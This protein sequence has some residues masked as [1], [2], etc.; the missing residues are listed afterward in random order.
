MSAV[1][2]C[3]LTRHHALLSSHRCYPINT[4]WVSPIIFQTFYYMAT[5]LAIEIPG[6]PVS[7]YAAY[8]VATLVGTAILPSLVYGI[9]T[10]LIF[11]ILRLLWEGRAADTRKR[12]LLMTTY[13]VLVCA[14]CTAHWVLN[15]VGE[16]LSLVE[17][18]LPSNKSQPDVGKEFLYASPVTTLAF[19]GIYITLTCVTD[20]LL[21]RVE[22]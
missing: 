1:N 13:V 9:N 20:G 10:T 3:I 8:N 19:D 15:C 4:L 21:V 7:D 14:L 6:S 5:P 18:T 17:I 22:A 11:L 16:A 12:T 2:G